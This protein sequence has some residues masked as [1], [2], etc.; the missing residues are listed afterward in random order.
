[1]S[2]TVDSR[3]VEMRFDNKNFEQNVS[4][5]MS[6]LEKL[7]QSLH[8]TGASKG[9]E[10]VS[11][12]AKNVDMNGLGNSVETVR[13]RF[14]ALEVM[15]VTA[16]ANIT[17]SAVNAGKRIVSA[18]TIDPVKTGFNEYELK[19][20][21]VKTIMAST[22]ESVETVN[23]YLEELNE[24]SDQT[25]YSFSDMTQNIGKFTNAGVKLDDAVLAIK[26]ISNEAAVSGAN[27]NEASRAMYNFSQALSAGYVKLIDWKSIENANMA[28]VEFKEQL[29]ESAVACGTLTKAGD[30][31]YKT[32]GG[33]T[34]NATKNFN[35]TLQEQWMT[36]EV[37]IETL[38]KYSDANTDIGKKAFAAAQDVTKLT[39]MF[40]VL[41]ETAQ[42]GWAKT[43]ELI[44][45]NI[46]QAK[47]VFTPLTDFFSN[48]INTVSD[49]RNNVLE[50]ALTLAKPFQE[51]SDKIQSVTKVTEKVNEVL[52]D[53]DEIVNRIIGGE[54]GNGQA[55]WDKLTE[56]GYDWA[57][58]QNLVNEKLGDSHRYQTDYTEAIEG[59]NKAQSTTLE[60][61]LKM[62]EAQLKHIGFTEDEIEAF[63][64]LAK[65]AEK[66]GIPIEELV[67]DMDQ[68]S[69]RSLLINSFK[70][71]GKGLVAVFQSLKTAWQ[72]AFPPKSIEERAKA[73]YDLVAALHKFTSKFALSSEEIK[74]QLKDGD[75]TL[76]KLTRTFKGLF[77]IIDVIT[78][79]VGGGFKAAFK[80]VTTLLGYFNMD[81]LDL[82]AKIGDLLVRFRDW[83]DEHNLLVKAIEWLAPYLEKVVKAISKFITHIKEAGYIKRFADWIKEA[84]KAIGDWFKKIKNS[85]QI[86]SFINYLKK[87]ATAIKDWVKGIK[88]ADNIPQ[89]I[90][91]GLVN[92]LKSGVKKVYGLVK[93]FGS[94][95][96][97]IIKDVLGIH[98]PSTVFIAIGGFIMAGLLI[99]LQNGAG[100]VWDFLRDLGSKCIDIIKEI[101]FGGLI[102][103]AIVGGVVLGFVKL[104]DAIHNFSKMFKGLSDM[105]EEF[106]DAVK[107]MSQ[108]VR[109]YLNSQAILNFAI[110]IAILAASLVVLS[111]INPAKLWNAFGVVAALAAVLGV[112][113]IVI[114]SLGKTKVDGKVTKISLEVGK[115]ALLFASLGAAILLMAISLRMLG[116]MDMAEL[117][118]GAVAVLLL[119]GIM[120]GL[121]W[122]TQLLARS[123][124]STATMKLDTIDSNLNKIGGMLLK[125][126]VAMLLMAVALKMIGKLDTASYRKGVGAIALFGVLIIGVMAAT[127]LLAA[128]YSTL[129]V[130]GM[131]IKLGACLL[132]MAIAV[133]MVGE[134]DT[135]AIVQGMI[136]IGLFGVMIVGLMWATKLFTANDKSAASIGTAI[137]GIGAAILAMALAVKIMGGMDLASM[138]K[139]LLA[140]LVFSGIVVGLIAATKLA[141]TN[142]V[143]K[144]GTLLIL[145][146]AAI[147]ILAGI[148][149][150]LGIMSWK[151]LLKGVLA[152]AALSGIMVGLIAATKLAPENELKNVGKTLV[153]VAAAIAILAGVAVILGLVKTEN[154]VKGIVAVGVLSVIMVMLM[155]TT[156]GIQTST[157]ALIA[158][159]IAI[160]VLAASA[161]ALS[162]LDTTKLLAATAA[163]SVLLGMF[164]VLLES[165]SNITSSLGT[166]IVMT[167]AI[168]VMAGALFLVGQLP[169]DTALSSAIALSAV[170][171]AM[172]VALNLVSK[173]KI[174]S[175]L[176]GVI[177]LAALGLV[178][179][180][181]IAILKKMDGMDN[182][183]DNVLAISVLMIAMSGVLAVVGAVGTF[184][185]GPY[186]LGLVAGV[187][188]LAALGLVM[189]E[190]IAILKKMDGM[191]DATA[192][193]IAIS[194][195]MLVMSEVLLITAAVGTIYAASFGLAVTGLIGLLALVEGL[196]ILIETLKEIPAD[197][198][199]EAQLNTV[200]F[201]A[202]ALKVLAKASKDIPNSGGLLGALLGN[203]DLGAF[204][205]QFPELGRGLRGFLDNV[206]TFTDGEVAT[207][208]C[209]AEAVKNLAEASKNI[210]GQTSWGKAIFGD[211]SLTAFAEEFPALGIGIRAFIA[212]VGPL[213]DSAIQT[214]NSALQV[215]KD[216]AEVAN[217]IDG[218]TSWGKAIFGDNSLSTFADQF[219]ELGKGLRGFLDNIGT[220][221][222]DGLS[223]VKCAAT[224]VKELAK[225]SEDIPNS[226][227]WFGGICGENDL[228]TFATQF[229][230]LGYGLRMF[231]ASIGTFAEAEL[232]TVKYSAKAVSEIAK[233]SEDIPNSGG[234]FGWIV[235][236]NNLG[237]FATQF[238]LLGFGLAGFV[239][240]IGTFTDAEV[241]T[242]NCA[243]KAIVSLAE[244]SSH[245][246]G[247]TEVGWIRKLFGDNSLS[248]LA[249]QLGSLGSGIASFA[250]NLGTFDEAKVTT[251]QYA[252]RALNSITSLANTDIKS[253][254]N[255]IPKFGDS[256]VDLAGD[257]TSFC[258]KMPTLEAVKS[259]TSGVKNVFTTMADITQTDSPA[260][261]SLCKS[262]K[263][264][265]KS[266]LESFI[267][268]FT[269]GSAQSEVKKA[270]KTMI[271]TL[272]EGM[273]DKVSKIENAAKDIAKDGAKAAS[274]ED[275]EFESAGKDLVEGFANGIELHTYVATQ[276]A[277]AMAAAAA[278][279]AKD[280]LDINS[281][282]KVFRAIASSI[283][284]G[285]ADGIERYSYLVENSSVS[286]A[287][288]AVSGVKD[289]I[290]RIA[291]FIDSDIDTQPTIRPVLDLSDVRSNA[292]LISSLLGTGTSMDV[293][294]NVGSINTMMNRRNQNGTNLDVI[295]AINKLR[296]DIGN[297][298]NTSYNIN[299]ITYDDGSNIANAIETI[300]RAAKVE[301]RR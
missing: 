103:T 286:M 160:A 82:T 280:E 37:L 116:K 77:A 258:E 35:E 132:L 169:A 117:G 92:G 81:I 89:Y 106:G 253:A 220:F 42:S 174:T 282:S 267:K 176:I 270:G 192:N 189:W 186:G 246:D 11:A 27:A 20:D 105:F 7:K 110:A 264:L 215:I 72:D 98:S 4:T 199:T 31:L 127:R 30:G 182:A 213:D 87:S 119:A 56:M 125:M 17:N 262:L 15:G 170:I 238:P 287:N 198:F 254:K 208:K 226:G 142:D 247:Q 79:V 158:I 71:V 236:D 122:A 126:A 183:I 33:E 190:F 277:R 13:S 129:A 102:A 203:N 180:E 296:K 204:A 209:A 222:E 234:W 65:Y 57:H 115:L 52:K 147:A 260:I 12:A 223:A 179:W 97:E 175:A 214:I 24:Y 188:G 43:W 252:V 118:K 121:M 290:S 269:N 146:A 245:I 85:K 255:N 154:L 235:G 22:G 55:R 221:T 227:G 67:K 181:F 212:A 272:A 196:P 168:A 228:G 41:K 283:P 205:E 50:G 156:S 163:I 210:D 8:L 76:G 70:N 32:L 91:S 206:G 229:P 279:A 274:K 153:L 74:K 162:L 90:L 61:L 293:L 244:A 140:V 10:N 63:K 231:T 291:D 292:G 157:G 152:V 107:I 298:N 68:L 250:N 45:G 159:S 249:T 66:T 6:T 100:P 217:N 148:T 44:F 101:D 112:L 16:L 207:I 265:A 194:A 84:G 80:V 164:R 225:V 145:I 25:I 161:V 38:K 123:A 155:K 62:D 133:K 256:I 64:E 273:K 266:G 171:L 233:A 284:E 108:G 60:Q 69:G 34:M 278:A 295:S 94:K 14:S 9:L 88:E 113:I 230:L 141:T 48:I 51:L 224:A 83:V 5:T 114:S 173:M 150:L 184:M 219:P 19:M 1:M 144:A 131:L 197:G 29:I 99:G 300:V 109:N 301:R 297:I 200:I 271:E 237:T 151:T 167:V 120:V 47:A 75:S 294:T 137:L 263:E 58:A 289:S 172:S 268:G 46:N 191:E 202:E 232:E 211:N 40:D 165:K 288:T 54:F 261:Q 3:V 39:Q 251:V 239:G 275:S 128:N 23:K 185:S 59:T 36:S 104:V 96:V 240:A 281:P 21:S 53:Y 130:D 18:L 218:Q 28:T 111:M 149:V 248:G 276:A 2:T 73:L 299:G 78:T 243:S 187:A 257:I 26:G 166:L 135:R 134:L 136:A 193:A 49:F 216:L 93:E 259:A 177:G 95:I 195:L 124:K 139:G 178:M 241:T 86:Q 138:A 143:A 201:A 242:V 285:F